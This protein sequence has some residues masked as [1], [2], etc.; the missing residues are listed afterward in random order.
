M[1]NSE[2]TPWCAGKMGP[3]RDLIG[4]LAKAVRR[5]DLI[6]GVSSHRME[7]QISRI[8]RRAFRTIEFDPKYAGFYGPP[9][10][11]EDER[12]QRVAAFQGDWLARVQELVESISRR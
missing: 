12:R 11:G 6:F 8:P 10:P 5:Q 3:K 9:I 2:I 4:E 1:W 7:H